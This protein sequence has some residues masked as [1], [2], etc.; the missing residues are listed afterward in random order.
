MTAKSAMTKRIAL[1]FMQH[2]P[3]DTTDTPEND[4]D[5]MVLDVTD[6]LKNF[7]KNIPGLKFAYLSDFLLGHGIDIV[8]DGARSAMIWSEDAEVMRHIM[9]TTFTK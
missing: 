2:G 1:L 9:H 6:E 7:A 8:R 5:A 3:D 4:I